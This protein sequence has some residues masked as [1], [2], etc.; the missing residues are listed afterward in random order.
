MEVHVKA[1]VP[2]GVQ[3]D[4][5]KYT[6]YVGLKNQGATCYMNSLLQT[7]FFT[8]KL[9]KAV[10]LMPTESDDSSKSVALAL[11]RVFYEL[12]F[13]DKPVGTKKLTKSFG[14]ETLDSFMQHDVQEL[15]RVLLDNIE[16]KMKNT[17]V[18]GTIPKLFEGK[19]ISFIR[20][21]H[22][23]F[24]SHRTEPFY[25]IQLNI[26]GKQNIYDSFNEYVTIETL[27]G[28]NKYDAG[29][30]GM[31]EAEKGIIFES[32]PPVLHLHLLRFQYDPLTDNNV[33]I[34]DRFE[35][36]EQIDL[37]KYLKQNNNNF[38]SDSNDNN[39]STFNKPY[40]SF[41]KDYKDQE[42]LNQNSLN[43]NNKNQNESATYILH[44]VLVHSGDNHGGH[45]VVF[46][47]PKGDGNWCKFDDDVVSVCSKT[48]A[49][50]NN[51][52][53][54]EDETSKHCT[55]AYM[56]VYIRQN[57][58]VLEPVTEE[59]IPSELVE[60]L[61]EEKRQETLRRKERTDQH[62][63]LT[64]NA[65]TECSFMGHRGNDLFDGDKTVYKTFKINKSFNYQ[66]TL[67]AIG[68]ELNYPPHGI[69]L[70]Q[71][72]RRDNDTMRPCALDLSDRDRTIEEILDKSASIF[73]V[74]LELIK[75]SRSLEALP[76]REP[77]DVLLFFKY[78]DPLNEFITYCGYDFINENSKFTSL[79]S[80]LNDKI[81]LPANTP[82]LLYEEVR[83]DACNE[84]LDLNVTLKQ[85]L[86]DLMDGDIICFQRDDL[87]KSR[88]IKLPTVVDYFK[89]LNNRIEVVL[90][91][92]NIQNDTGFVLELSKNMNYEELS[93]AVAQRLNTEPDLIQF[94]RIQ[95]YFYFKFLN[96]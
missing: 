92:K 90:C 6:G 37:S 89:D 42:L 1:D 45:Y 64:I 46:I 47:N 74:F 65:Y 60:R 3:W 88:S 33:K 11:Q 40:N 62:L 28:E 58:D 4:S 29:D 48:E 2:H 94:Y 10:Y 85:A 59:S 55:N 27:N 49:I 81:G 75:P 12:Q 61:K 22:V 52:G 13:S 32:F 25:D 34:N 5:K 53:G 36:H 82:L 54:T 30:F 69:R 16:S 84:V 51:F 70:W 31:Q 77:G 95:K 15:C 50:S 24:H 93:K 68:A 8:N 41:L 21:K 72:V 57:S 67:N 38:N 86:D 20:C 71:I 87:A 79:V 39:S 9:R 73:Y 63:Y 91:D 44:A 7:L 35:F 56:L 96:F 23:E 76:E 43:N 66:Q 83:P 80:K 78:Y 14:W 17:C 19:M 18:A 26:K